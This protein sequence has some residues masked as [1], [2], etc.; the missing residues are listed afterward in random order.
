MSADRDREEEIFDTARELASDERAAYLA[1]RCGHDAELRQRLAAM[2]EA[3]AAAS[4]FFKTHDAPSPN[5]ILD[6]ASLSPSIE[7]VGD[8]IGRY[9][10]LEQ[11][12]EG[13]MG[14]VY[15]AEQDQ[16]VR[17]SVALKIIKLGMD[18]RQVVARFEAERQALAMMNHPHIAKVFD[19]GATDSG[20]P[21]F[22]MELVRGVPITD[23]C[24]KNCLPTRERLELFIL[25][26]QAVQHAHQKGVIHRDLKP[27]NI[28]VTLNDGVPWPMIID[29]G[30]AKATHQ[31]LTEKTL[32]TH[33]AQMIGTPAYMSPEQAEMSKLDVDTRTDIYALGVLL[34]ELLTGTTPILAKELLSLGYREMQRTIAEREPLRLS[35]RL[36]TMANE[37]R[38]IVAT[39]RSTEASSLAKLFSGDLDWIAIKCLEKDR[40]RRYETANGLA[41]DV[42][43][44]LNNEPV[45]ARPPSNFYRL[46]KLIRRNKPV[47]AAAAAIATILV[48]AVVV[49]TWQAF[50]ATRSEREQ[51]RLREETERARVGEIGQRER[52]EAQ[53]AI[54]R[55][56]LYVAT[57]NL[58]W[59]AW[60]EG[61]VAKV[62]AALKGL[63]PAD[64]REDLRGFEWHYLNRLLH[65]ESAVLRPGGQARV[66]VFSPDG[67]TLVSA[68]SD[69][70]PAPLDWKNSKG[71]WTTETNRMQLTLWRRSDKQRIRSFA[72]HLRMVHAACFSPDG[73]RL[74]SGGADM[75]VRLWRVE[76]GQEL[77]ALAGHTDEVACVAFSPDGAT[78][79]S[80]AA[81]PRAGFGANEVTRFA[82]YSGDQQE[83][84]LW[85][86]STGELLWKI[87]AHRDGVLSIAFSKDGRTLA[88]AGLDSN[89]RLWDT[90]NGVLRSQSK[91]GNA[92]LFSAA[93]SP[94]GN[95]LLCGGEDGYLTLWD[96][97]SGTLERI[98][99]NQQHVFAVAFSPSGTTVASAG[100]DKTVRLWDLAN[101][102]TRM[103][104]RGHASFVW[105]LGFSPDSGTLAS[106]GWDGS[107]RLWDVAQTSSSRV[108]EERPH[109]LA[110][111]YSKDGRTLVTGSKQ[112]ELWDPV[113]FEHLS[114]L[115][116]T[117]I[118]EIYVLRFSPDGKQLAAAGRDGVLK[119]WDTENWTERFSHERLGGVW[120]LAYSPDSSTLVSGGKNG[121][122]DCWNAF[123]GEHAHTLPQL[124]DYVQS[125]AFS[126]DGK[127]LV[128]AGRTPDPKR[129]MIHL[130]EWKQRR[131]Q[132]AL[133]T[134]EGGRILFSPDGK[135]FV[136]GSSA[137]DGRVQFWDADPP[138]LRAETRGHTDMVWDL[139][140]SPDGRTL[141]TASWDGSVRLWHVATGLEL[142]SFKD[143]AHSQCWAVQFSPDGKQL[144]ATG[145]GGRL[146]AWETE[147]NTGRRALR[148]RGSSDDTDDYSLAERS[149]N[150]SRRSLLPTQPPKY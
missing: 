116:D 1:G 127:T 117:N 85:N 102:S 97:R 60:E 37:E 3:D 132:R 133:P 135:T 138:K 124:M 31:R 88:S 87:A 139:T 91:I 143:P 66:V 71:A 32:F 28:L 141:A 72:G 120:A 74:A 45:V 80:G 93:F 67:Q 62:G 56:R 54:A 137:T 104:L 19:A 142:F 101:R 18:T 47:F 108:S 96:L 69:I 79:A 70:S 148:A 51:K 107:V 147:E 2:L 58:A 77:M 36:S 6:H 76:D 25:V 15:M 109:P 52:A 131:L 129:N 103:T 118:G 42:Q 84:R 130:W 114:T 128:V 48:L 33:F 38:T 119:V 39:N 99:S 44:Y 21:F 61:D 23:Y 125:A 75:L 57:I 94:D 89:V 122:V 106:A 73:N 92:R 136:R 53:G 90:A 140:F 121:Q 40:T 27:S 112:I 145:T 35:T 43:R 12:G 50:R 46:Q 4:K 115:A 64:G 14:L 81:R 55:Q 41:A 111:A 110:I 17:R 82:D 7:K 65:P 123:S 126:P 5:L 150:T 134:G 16:P 63:L 30:I 146:V 20:R 113:T 22:V 13:G 100:Y 98:L 29:F 68:G 26:C 149:Q 83:I 78:V 24:D 10:L 105:S 8:R 11:I 59:R 86:A 49:S 34:Y 9:K 95:T 144:V